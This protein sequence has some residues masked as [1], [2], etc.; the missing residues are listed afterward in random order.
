MSQ[1]TNVCPVRSLE[2]NVWAK[3]KDYKKALQSNLKDIFEKILDELEQNP[4][5]PPT[6][7]LLGYPIPTF[8]KRVNIKHRIVYNVDNEN[9]VVKI[10]SMWS[11][12]ETI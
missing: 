10:L 9:N 3:S 12:Y 6:E 4:Y 5:Q 8:S 11:H 1:S 7:K 2:N